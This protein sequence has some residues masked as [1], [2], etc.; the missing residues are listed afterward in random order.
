MECQ[1]RI[2]TSNKSYLSGFLSTMF[3]KVDVVS[4]SNRS[5]HQIVKSAKIRDYFICTNKSV[6]GRIRSIVSARD[7]S[8]CLRVS[9]S[10]LYT[11]VFLR[12]VVE[13]VEFVTERRIKILAGASTPYSLI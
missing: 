3:T 10:L 5:N 4:V 2:V 7:W 9:T 1:V 13:H 6:G 8:D 11:T 12:R